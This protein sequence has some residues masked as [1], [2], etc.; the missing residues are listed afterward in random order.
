MSISE[1]LALSL[2]LSVAASALVWVVGALVERVSPDPRLRDR[3]WGA[4]L[5]LS[6][7]PPLAVAA[8]LLAPA[9]VR[10]VA[11]P[12]IVM[13]PIMVASTVQTGAVP[14]PAALPD[15]EVFAS[16]FLMA[17]VGMSLLRL[18]SLA[19]RVGRL[20]RLLRHA[21]PADAD[22]T[23]LVEAIGERLDIQPPRTV[24]SATVSEALLSGLG[25][26]C[27][28]LPQTTD[29]VASE[30][31]IAHELAHLKRGDH[32]TLWLEEALVVLLAINPLVPVLRARRDAAR[33][34]A[35]DALALAAAE[36]AVRRAYA[37]TL[38]EALRTRAGPRAMG[39]AV[40]AL[41][42]TGAGRTSA[43]H[44]LK[45]VMTP[46]APAGRR[47]RLIALSLT[48]GLVA[49][50]GGAS[51]AVADQRPVRTVVR[52]D[53]D[54]PTSTP[55]FAYVGAAL[56]PIYRAAWPD[57]CGFGSESNG[58]VFVHA[59]D[60]ATGDGTK[61]EILSLA[62]VA[63]SAEA[64]D[65]F[66]AVKASCD[67]GR[68]V[69]IAYVENGARDR[70]SVACLSP[71]VA[72]PEPV[73]FTVDLSYD[74][75]IRIAAGDKLEIE[76][77]RDME[78][79]GTA[80]S[81]IVLD[82]APGALPGQAFA[83]LPPPLLPADL[84]AGPMF[85]LSA[86]IVG[87][88][89]AVK[90]VSDRDLG[91]PH[92]PYLTRADAVSTAMRML[93]ANIP[94]VQAASPDLPDGPALTVRI[95]QSNGPLVLGLQ[96]VLRVALQSQ[97]GARDITRLEFPIA[98]NQ[99][100]EREVRLPIKDAQ[101]PTLTR[102]RTYELTAEI[103]DA[104]GRALY[105]ADPVTVRMG[106]G[107]RGRLAGMRPELVL[108][109]TTATQAPAAPRAYQARLTITD[110]GQIVASG[111]M[112][113]VPGDGAVTTLNADGRE[114]QF[115]LSLEGPESDP[116]GAGSLTVRAD[117]GRAA[118]AGGWEPVARPVLLFQPDAQ[119]RMNWGSDAGLEFD[120]VVEPA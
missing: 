70:V 52:A 41:T 76:L 36:P 59:G 48:V 64:H 10:E 118:D 73:R 77:K 104:E 71:A 30:A 93:P 19:V 9:P 56:D 117:V 87:T 72:P 7:V 85:A 83:D 67:A 20:T 96:S 89:G 101:L 15:L 49:T 82:L 18:V 99:P 78:Q 92:A 115:D 28:I 26:P 50:V 23:R 5:L 114:Y 16:L 53:A 27:L 6:A 29:E 107:S 1:L 37:Q 111:R 22:L 34:E 32:R 40:A 68:P 113:L 62:G 24:V 80:S 110:K 100:L 43:M 60:C 97:D 39:D 112:R 84:R 55:D 35:C 79:G 61:I 8:L 69:E 66:A 11:A 2:V 75:A 119:A 57:A 31:V 109:R 21:A 3:V 108:A 38:I 45:A 94:V 65:A 47:A 95:G 91:R 102:G 105:V 88:D 103:W 42:F 90:A 4:G 63:F 86:R 51:W 120:I 58:K 81:S 74:P 17:A 13:A 98:S 12:A 44:R 46:A 116:R 14:T 33:E 106:P 54:G 25:R